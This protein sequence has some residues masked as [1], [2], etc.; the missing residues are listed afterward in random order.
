MFVLGCQT[1]TDLSN[2]PKESARDQNILRRLESIEEYAGRRERGRVKSETNGL[3]QMMGHAPKPTDGRHLV[4]IAT[5]CEQVGLPALAGDAY[6]KAGQ[7][8]KALLCA[9]EDEEYGQADALRQRIE[10]EKPDQSKV[11]TREQIKDFTSKVE[12][13]FSS[14]GGEAVKS[15]TEEVRSTIRDSQGEGTVRFTQIRLA[16][17][18]IARSGELFAENSKDLAGEFLAGGLSLLRDAAVSELRQ[19]R[20]ADAPVY[21]AY[22]NSKFEDA[23]NYLTFRQKFLPDP[24]FESKRT[25]LQ[26][27]QKRAPGN[28]FGEPY[29]FSQA[30]AGQEAATYIHLW[31]PSG[32]QIKRAWERHLAEPDYR[33][34]AKAAEPNGVKL[35]VWDGNEYDF[36]FEI[37]TGFRLP[38]APG[39]Y[40]R[41]LGVKGSEASPR[42]ALY[43]QGTFERAQL[44]IHEISWK[45]EERKEL[46]R[47]AADF[48]AS[49]TGDMD[50]L[51][52]GSIRYNSAVK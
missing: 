52:F 16:E 44:M 5:A 34:E 33:I 20:L 1:S 21:T 11:D 43:Q 50:E 6:E 46:V 35:S 32:R 38:F 47:F 9:T 10:A 30:K 37:S 15:T 17:T 14:G 12:T 4:R 49:N 40:D 7:L 39:Y 8:E 25:L 42:L 24:R 36:I 2:K 13:A 3:L 29:P 19:Y 48:V 41:V 22:R 26:F 31:D 23:L 45:T 27:A 28:L 51:C 18:W